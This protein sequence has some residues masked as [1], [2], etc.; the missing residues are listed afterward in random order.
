M[1]I[2]VFINVIFTNSLW[3]L[4]ISVILQIRKL[5]HTSSNLPQITQ[6]GSGTGNTYIKCGDQSPNF[7]M[8]LVR[9][10]LFGIKKQTKHL[11]IEELQKDKAIKQVWLF[12]QTCY[13]RFPPWRDQLQK[14]FPFCWLTAFLVW[15][16]SL[17]KKDLG[18][19]SHYHSCTLR[20][21]LELVWSQQRCQL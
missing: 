6:R 7:T 10:A 16:H 20:W 17:A 1:I 18:L 5:R 8:A 11:Q 19:D 2:H 9:K 4:M 12:C 3:D 15:I 13:K 14:S 21:G